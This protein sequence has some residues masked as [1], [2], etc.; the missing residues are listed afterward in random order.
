[1]NAQ[2]TSVWSG[3]NFFS[4][5]LVIAVGLSFTFVALVGLFIQQGAFTGAFLRPIDVLTYSA[6]IHMVRLFGGEI[7]TAFMQR[8]I[9]VR[10]QLHSN[11]I[12]LHVDAAGWL[13]AERLTLLAGGVATA[14]S[15]T[16]EA[17][18]RAVVL[19]S[20]QVGQQAFTLAYIDGFLIIACVCVGIM[21]L[22]ALM[23][24][25]KM[26]FDSS[27]SDPPGK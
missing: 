6:F 8:L 11:L 10:E 4:S 23:R 9:A 5:Q 13:S 3:D 27:S 21:L 16:D 24:P 22:I 12:G 25:M 18:Q 7:G 26:L 1:M 2:L 20:G 19:L 17:Q 15:G 14:S